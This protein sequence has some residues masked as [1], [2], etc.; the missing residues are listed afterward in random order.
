MNYTVS[1]I[2]KIDERF[3]INEVDKYIKSIRLSPDGF[4]YVVTEAESRQHIALRDYQFGT[5]VSIKR[6]E[7][8]LTDLFENEDILGGQHNHLNISYVNRPWGMVPE[9]LLV[10]DKLPQLINVNFKKDDFAHTTHA[11][12]PGTDQFFASRIPSGWQ[13]VL[14]NKAKHINFIPHQSALAYNALNTLKYNNLPN[15]FFVLLHSGFF[16]LLYIENHKIVFYNNFLYN[17]YADV[18]YFVLST[19]EK[20]EVIAKESHIF[21]QGNDLVKEILPSELK[22]HIQYVYLDKELY[23]EHYSP[24]FDQLPL[25]KYKLLTGINA[26]G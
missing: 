21:L 10:E 9:M 17:Q 1:T 25:Y 18:L 11:R 24:Q 15:A 23:G 8:I 19:L 5:E 16:D 3:N 12:I 26:C 13:K 6:G 22:K 2:E 14:Q 4:S 7:E 20:M